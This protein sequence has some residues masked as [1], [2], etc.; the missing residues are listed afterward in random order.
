[1]PVTI[2][3]RPKTRRS[4]LG[5]QTNTCVNFSSNDNKNADSTLPRKSYKPVF[6]VEEAT[7]TCTN[8][9]NPLVIQEDDN[10]HQPTKLKRVD[11]FSDS[12]WDDVMTKDTGNKKND[13]CRASLVSVSNYILY[14][15][16]STP[17][18]ELFNLPTSF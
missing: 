14:I 1:M 12:T 7:T 17:T 13:E 9:I 5:D 11:V 18:I 15:L 4:A 3:P 16:N 10:T 8:K 6:Q 2:A